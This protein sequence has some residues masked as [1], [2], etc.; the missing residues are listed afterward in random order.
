MRRVNEA[1]AIAA[2]GAVGFGGGYYMYKSFETDP[3]KANAKVVAC[4]HKLGSRAVLSQTLPHACHPY[5][6]DLVKDV[7]SKTR[8]SPD[9]QG[10]EVEDVLYSQTVYH[11]PSADTLMEMERFT[12]ADHRQERNLYI[13]FML[14]FGFGSLAIGTGGV[15]IYEQRR[16]DAQ[17][18]TPA[19]PAQS[20]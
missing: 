11:L 4:A 9:D 3:A 7:S 6:G 17:Q 20:S 5:E 13:M 10:T 14:A 18:Q 15:A 16:N 2:A 19:D 8:I 12:P 1:L